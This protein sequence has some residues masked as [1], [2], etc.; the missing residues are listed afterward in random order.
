MSNRKKNSGISEVPP[1]PL[2]PLSERRWLTL[3]EA[4]CYLSLSAN[5]VRHFLH[6]GELRAVRIGLM[7]RVDRTD[8]DQF[9]LR[10]SQIVAPYRRGTRP[11][12]SK[13]WAEY[14]AAKQSKQKRVAR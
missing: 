7:F 14:R 1:P 3:P 2:V 9:M 4:A 5:T 6:S 12:V 8:L 11:A 10:R 13:R